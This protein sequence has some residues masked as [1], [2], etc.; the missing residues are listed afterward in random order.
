MLRFSH[1]LNVQ[2]KCH[3]RESDIDMAVS[4]IVQGQLSWQA[5]A[6]IA[7][8]TALYLVGADLPYSAL[9]PMEIA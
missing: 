4:L 6:R 1:Q 8:G 2:G 3:Y 7:C 9:K 5:I